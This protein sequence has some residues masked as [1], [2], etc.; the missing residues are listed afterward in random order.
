MMKSLLL[1]S[2]LVSIAISRENPFFSTSNNPNTVVTS[3]KNFNKPKLQSMTYSFP[4][5]ARL[6][7]DISFTFQNIDGSTETRRLEV[8]Q[9][10]DW[11]SPIVISQSS[12]VKIDSPSSKVISQ[13][14]PSFVQIKNL[15]NKLTLNTHASLLRHFTLSDPYSVVVDF[16]HSEIFDGFDKVINSSPYVKARVSNHGKF[17]R[18]T[19]VLDGRHQC[20]VSAIAQGAEVICK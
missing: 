13:N 1:A 12:K 19:V 2:L 17:S 16:K 14:H 8:D 3:E 20:S 18:V 9:S 11:R 5:Q 15:G 4:D 7:K 6:L 10:I